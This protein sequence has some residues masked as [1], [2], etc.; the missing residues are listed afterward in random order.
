LYCNNWQAFLFNLFV[1]RLDRILFLALGIYQVQGTWAFVD[2]CAI[3]FRGFNWCRNAHVDSRG[4][5][6]I[7]F[8]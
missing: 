4:T 2:I 6:V 7:V 3:V 1:A 5:P 8:A